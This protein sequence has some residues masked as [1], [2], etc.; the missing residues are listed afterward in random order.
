MRA[1]ILTIRCLTSSVPPQVN[2]LTRAVSWGHPR[3]VRS[4]RTDPVIRVSHASPVWSRP[5]TL[6]WCCVVYECPAPDP[7][8]PPLRTPCSVTRRLPPWRGTHGTRLGLSRSGGPTPP[9]VVRT[10]GSMSSK[11]RPGRFDGSRCTTLRTA[12]PFPRP[13]V[14]FWVCP[15]RP[16]GHGSPRSAGRR[17]IGAVV[18]TNPDGWSG[19]KSARGYQAPL[20]I[21][22]SAARSADCCRSLGGQTVGG[23]RASV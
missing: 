17:P 12:W 16:Q 15:S 5:Y 4:E 10:G 3:V 2:K 18:P 21:K 22:A 20:R 7:H 13:P 11:T 14:C 6:L 1:L 23:A 8:G 19:R 9:N